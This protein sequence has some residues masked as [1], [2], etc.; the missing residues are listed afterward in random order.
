MSNQVNDFGIVLAFLM[1]RQ[2]RGVNNK[3]AEHLG[4]SAGFVTKIKKGDRLPDRSKM[5]SISQFFGLTLRQFFLLAEA[6]K[7]RDEKTKQ[8]ILTISDQSIELEAAPSFVCKCETKKSLEPELVGV[9]WEKLEGK[10]VMLLKDMP[11]GKTFWMA[12]IKTDD[13]F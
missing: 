13:L 9:G 11:A 3:L 5:Q 6:I 2:D 10:V 1:E 8:T 12:P 4:T 7:N